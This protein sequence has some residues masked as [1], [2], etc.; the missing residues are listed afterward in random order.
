M[1]DFIQ[2]NPL[3][4]G[5]IG[6]TVGMLIATALPKSD[7]EEDIM[8]GVSAE[9]RK[10]ASELASQQF[11]TVKALASEGITESLIMPVRKALCLPI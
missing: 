5:G 9:V 6:L 10:R 3:L 11:D 2:R 1:S 4:F 8:G 7:I